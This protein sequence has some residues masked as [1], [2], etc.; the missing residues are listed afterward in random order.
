MKIGMTGCIR[1][2]RLLSGVL[3]FAGCSIG[4]ATPIVATRPGPPPVDLGSAA[5]YAILA[6]SGISAI[7]FSLIVGDIGISPATESL[8][9]GFS[10]TRVIAYS[11]SQQVT[12]FMYAADMAAPTPAKMGAAIVDMETA[13]ADAAGRECPDH[14]D[15]FSGLLGGNLFLPGL[16]KWNTRVLVLSDVTVSGGV[17]DL[18]VFQISGDLVVNYAVNFILAGGAQPKN[19]FWQVAGTVTL[20][21]ASRVEGI[22]LCKTS[23][24]LNTGARINGRAFAQ[25]SVAL[26]KAIVTE[27]A[28]QLA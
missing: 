25:T 3:G 12:G 20:G 14:L 16:Y 5:N 10:Q 1:I 15:D 18:W 17:D 26:D 24:T 4:D 11:T 21:T 9:T 6:K 2:T 27:P 22:I 23:I 19:I 28:L 8:M 13:Y 7:P